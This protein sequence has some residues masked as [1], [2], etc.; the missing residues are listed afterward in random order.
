MGV[1]SRVA[2]TSPASF[3]YMFNH[4]RREHSRHPGRSRPDIDAHKKIVASPTSADALQKDSQLLLHTHHLPL[5][6]LWRPSSTAE[7]AVSL[8]VQPSV[9]SLSSIILNLFIV[10]IS[11]TICSW[12]RLK[13]LFR[14]TMD[15][16]FYSVP[17]VSLCVY[18]CIRCR[19]QK[20][21]SSDPFTIL[22]KV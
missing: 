12:L 20:S 15:D 10:P 18:T 13:A 17:P 4:P 14:T 8:S 11:S 22:I 2:L 3:R 7:P 9:M 21:L 5:T 1:K 16:C 6:S 19:S